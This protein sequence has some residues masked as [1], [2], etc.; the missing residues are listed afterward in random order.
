VKERERP[1]GLTLSDSNL[2][3]FRYCEGLQDLQFVMYLCVLT[4]STYI[5]ILL[6]SES[7]SFMDR[8]QFKFTVPEPHSWLILIV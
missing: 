4:D 6:L 7:Y 5:Q 8:F 1:V 3:G 2:I